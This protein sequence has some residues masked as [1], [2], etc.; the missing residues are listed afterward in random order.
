MFLILDVFIACRNRSVGASNLMTVC[1]L[2]LQGA[3][4]HTDS[5]PSLILIF[6]LTLLVLTLCTL[7]LA[8]YLY[9]V[10]YVY[11][12]TKSEDDDGSVARKVLKRLPHAF[13][14]VF[15]TD[16]WISLVAILVT[17]AWL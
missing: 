5:Q 4:V 12:D 1:Q 8:A 3:D 13:V 15:V 2:V 10:E 7:A 16:L 14:R 9:V 17:V 6:A 11:S